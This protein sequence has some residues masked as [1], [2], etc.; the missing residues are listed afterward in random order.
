MNAGVSGVVCVFQLPIGYGQKIRN[1]SRCVERYIDDI[2]GF[3][4]RGEA[5][6]SP[7][8]ADLRSEI[9]DR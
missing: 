2:A 6:A 3:D 9:M 1:E 8:P 4:K 5:R 7:M